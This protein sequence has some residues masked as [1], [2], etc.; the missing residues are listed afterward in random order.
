MGGTEV[1]GEQLDILID[2]VLDCSPHVHEDQLVHSQHALVDLVRQDGINALVEPLGQ[3]QLLDDEGR[4]VVP[5]DRFQA[6]QPVVD[7]RPFGVVGEVLKGLAQSL[8]QAI[9][10]WTQ[11]L[12]L[13]HY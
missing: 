9:R 7:V 4:G 5:E 1:G 6:Q 8:V 12:H 2:I 3:D 10:G 13:V 11:L